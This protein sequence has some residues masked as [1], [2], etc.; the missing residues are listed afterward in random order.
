MRHPVAS[1]VGQS[2]RDQVAACLRDLARAVPTVD[3]IERGGTIQNDETLRRI[4]ESW[5]GTTP[6]SCINLAQV[7]P[8]LG[9]FARGDVD[10]EAAA[11]PGD[12]AAG[13]LQRLLAQWLDVHAFVLQQGAQES[14]AT[15][16]LGVTDGATGPTVDLGELLTTA[17][18]GWDLLL[19]RSYTTALAVMPTVTV[20]DGD[21]R[22]P[23]PSAYYSFDAAHMTDKHVVDLVGDHHLDHTGVLVADGTGARITTNGSAPLRGARAYAPIGDATVSFW[24]DTSRVPAG[25]SYIVYSAGAIDV[26]IAPK[27]GSTTLATLT[28]GHG[29][30]YLTYDFTKGAWTHFAAVRVGNEYTLY[31]NGTYTAVVTFTTRPSASGNPTTLVLSAPATVTIDELALWQQSLSPSDVLALFQRGRA[32]SNRLAPLNT[33]WTTEVAPYAGERPDHDQHL[34]IATKIVET[35]ASH[36]G[37]L[38]AYAERSLAG[39]YGSCYAGGTST[40]QRDAMARTARGLR[41]LTAAT[42]LASDLHRRGSEVSCT[43]N[44]ECALAAPA[45]VALTCGTASVCVAADGTTFT[46]APAWDA[47][48]RAAATRLAASR[49]RAIAALGRLERC[50][51]PLGIPEDDLPL[52]FGDVTGDNARFFASSDYLMDR[53]ALP[54][55]REASAA[56][57]DARSAWQSMRQSN[58]QQ[59][60]TEHDAERRMEGLVKTFVQPIIDACGLTGYDPADV[61]PAF[62][63]GDLSVMSCFRFDRCS[64]D[65]GLCMRGQMGGAMLDIK[66]AANALRQEK[67]N[68]ERRQVE[69]DAHVATCERVQTSIGHDLEALA[70]FKAEA[71]EL[72]RKMDKGLAGRFG[73]LLDSVVSAVVPGEVTWFEDGMD[74]LSSCL[75]GAF[76]GAATG[77]ALAAPAGGVSAIGGAV[78]GAGVGCYLGVEGEAKEDSARDLDEARDRLNEALTSSSLMRES[79]ACWDEVNLRLR[80]VGFGIEF[81]KEQIIALEQSWFRFDELRRSTERSL[82]EARAVIAREE[83]RTVPSVAHHFW[84]DEKIARFRHEM[85][86]A[87]RM[88]FLAMRAIEFELQQSLGLRSAILSATHPD[89]LEAIAE[90]L[91]A[92]RGARSLNGRRPAAGTEV[93]SLRS[94]ILGLRDLAPQGAGER[95]DSA[96]R[97]LQEILTSPDYAVWNDDG[98]Y[99]GQAIPFR[100]SETGALRHRCAERLWRVSATVQG[101]ITDIAEPGTHILLRKSNVFQSQW[102]EGM[103]NG[104]AYQQASTSHTAN[105]L[106][107][108]DAPGAEDRAEFTNAVLFPWFNVRRSDFYR[109]AYTEG[110]SEEM[111]GRGLYGE[112][113]LIFPYHG[114]LEPD[115]ACNRDVDRSCADPFRHLRQVEDVLIRFD[116][117]SVDDLA[118]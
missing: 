2:A 38:Q 92:E 34:G 117:Y 6:G 75:G 100:L 55:V 23:R 31:V 107:A 63:R 87:R 95:T 24:L 64:R 16:A 67:R 59:T 22:T 71:K 68:Q 45:G 20:R 66:A 28:V 78:I 14:E 51:N 111:A 47:A 36:A 105:L 70:S 58:I 99:L 96:T 110:S 41:Y 91:D 5:F 52:Y 72:R 104:S 98:T 3:P 18:R 94:D 43:G 26:R 50:E 62:D 4:V 80:D 90:E 88:T 56:L 11:I 81:A 101:D 65:S 1:T 42:A 76:G 19:D 69:L 39:V 74:W 37:V 83:G 93:L 27:S 13:L 106:R 7:F 33:A 40:P 53:W 12:R 89:E 48:Y 60:M 114:M 21:Y 86:Q 32:P 57:A 97:R 116:Y 73:G 10:S 17:E 54:A 49:G 108:D 82:A 84:T 25:N 112:Y 85:E 79:N 103:G 113:V 46:A 15:A 77:A 61:I 44:L 118:N 115:P 30:P 29:S 8:A 9:S 109:D 35:A 102:C